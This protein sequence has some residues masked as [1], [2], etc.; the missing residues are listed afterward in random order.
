MVLENI[1]KPEEYATL[2][3]Q[4]TLVDYE[5]IVL[6]PPPQNRSFRVSFKNI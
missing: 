6:P 5:I 1:N 4:N 3:Y 2:H